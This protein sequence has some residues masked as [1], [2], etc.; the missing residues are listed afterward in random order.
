[1][2]SDTR[3]IWV[4][5]SSSIVDLKIIPHALRPQIIR[6]L[7]ALVGNGRLIYPR[8]VLDELKS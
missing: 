7:D 4:T 1:M 2:P 3:V 8:Q 6:H 5:D